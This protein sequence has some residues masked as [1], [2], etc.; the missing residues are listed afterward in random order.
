MLLSLLLPLTTTNRYP[1]LGALGRPANAW[2]LRELTRRKPDV[3][4]AL[5]D[6]QGVKPYTVSTLLD[7][8][9]RPLA[10]GTWL[11]PGQTCW[12]RVTTFEQRL[13]EMLLEMVKD[14]PPHLTLYKM[15]FRL[16][17]WTLDPAQHPWAGQTSFAALAQAERVNSRSREVRLEFASP[18]AF[19]SEGADTPLPIPALILRSLWQRWNAVVTQPMQIH[20]LWPEFAAACVKVSELT[21]VN[22]ERWVF[23]EG[24]RGAATGFTGTVG[25]TLLPERQC[26]D[27]AACWEGAD[28]VL[29]SL[30]QF[31]FY[32]GTGHHTTIGMGQTRC[33][34]P[35][36]KG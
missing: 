15:D 11:E 19:R 9:G 14:L 1:I 36:S 25:L 26:R 12:L 2:L 5:H 28:R 18:T 17:G 6:D 8:R 34:S 27:W 23:A 3:A 22:T 30:A 7:D 4:Q 24:T 20:A 33:V 31:A 10:T 32:C 21:A 13:S 16:D 29:Q 35:A